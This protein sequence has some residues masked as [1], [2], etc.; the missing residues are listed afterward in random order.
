M[1]REQ[2]TLGRAPG[3]SRRD[4]PQDN[5]GTSFG[6]GTSRYCLFYWSVTPIFFHD[7][8]FFF[9]RPSNGNRWKGRFKGAR[10]RKRGT[11][12]GEGGGGREE[13]RKERDREREGRGGAGKERKGKK[14]SFST[15][16]LGVAE[17]SSGSVAGRG[18]RGSSR[19]G[20]GCDKR[21]RLS[22]RSY[23]GER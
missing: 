8:F 13:G 4:P 1:I 21:N 17:A 6:P 9:S 15:G 16:C 10:F 2:Y 18:E 20:G 14:K 7:V 11:E 5:P 23:L 12:G 19:G 22:E 3:G